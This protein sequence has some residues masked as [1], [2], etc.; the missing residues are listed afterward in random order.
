MTSEERKW[1][2]SQS[3]SGL[4]DKWRNEPSGS[5]YFSDKERYKYFADRFDVMK[6][7]L[8]PDQL[9]I[10]SKRVGWGE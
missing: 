1:I 6:E 3:Y 4:L 7:E 5:G 9:V 8:T 2:D 10:A